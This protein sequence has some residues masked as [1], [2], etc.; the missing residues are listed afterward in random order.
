MYRA[1]VENNRENHEKN[2]RKQGWKK[3]KNWVDGISLSY[4]NS[5]YQAL[6]G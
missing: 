2:I 4:K 1:C 6:V 5:E 3:Q